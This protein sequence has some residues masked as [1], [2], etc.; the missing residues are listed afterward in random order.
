MSEEGG[1]IDCEE[2]VSCAFGG[3]VGRVLAGCCDR[4]RDGTG[5]MDLGRWLRRG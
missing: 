2:C 3:G 5:A 4:E 1:E